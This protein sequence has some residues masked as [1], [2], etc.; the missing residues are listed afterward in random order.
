[1][2]RI[3]ATGEDEPDDDDWYVFGRIAESF[4]LKQEAAAMYRRL[5]RPKLDIA[6][7]ATSYGLAQRRLKGL[8]PQ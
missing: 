7:P 8:A 2:Q 1:L 5:E 6:I 4:G 3:K